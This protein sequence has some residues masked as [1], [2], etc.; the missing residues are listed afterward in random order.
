MRPKIL[1]NPTAVH[2]AGHAIAANSLDS[3]I[4]IESIALHD[5]QSG[6]VQCVWIES[7]DERVVWD[8]CTVALAGITAEVLLCGEAEFSAAL[9][10][11][12]IATNAANH[13]S[14]QN[15]RFAM[16]RI[17]KYRNC[18]TGIK[19]ADPDKRRIADDLSTELL[20]AAHARAAVILKKKIISLLAISC[21]LAKHRKLEGLTLRLL[22][23]KQ[24]TQPA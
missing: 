6:L 3:I 17:K 23:G 24:K 15:Y 13:L 10:D 9:M 14:T 11:L 20:Q 12:F 5:D 22:L 4:K 1:F 2:E 8:H 21:I 19:L 18:W 7:D 16:S